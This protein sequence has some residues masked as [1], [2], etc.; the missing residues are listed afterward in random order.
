MRIFVTDITEFLICPIRLYLKKIKGIKKENEKMLKGRILHRTFEL[1]Y[2]R[3]KFLWE[4][5][6]STDQL[7]YNYLY[8]EY[9]FIGMQSLA[10]AILEE[11]PEKFAVVKE[12]LI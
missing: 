2:Q 3:E 6:S 8:K 4:N 1:F 11:N 7:N 10:R 12:E 5:L 9:N